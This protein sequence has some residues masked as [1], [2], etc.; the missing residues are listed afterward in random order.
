MNLRVFLP[1]TKQDFYRFIAREPEGRYEFE[2]GRIVQQMPGATRTH[3][4]LAKRIESLLEVQLDT[5][6]WEALYD[7]GVETAESVRYGDVVVSPVDE[8]ADSRATKRAA[9]VVEMLS[10]SSLARDLDV[11]PFEYMGLASLQ[12]YIV[13]SQTEAACLAWVRRSDGRFPPDPAEYQTNDVIAVPQLGIALSVAEIYRGI[14]LSSED[15]APH[16]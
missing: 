13:A 9:L 10:P 12:A 2:G 11:K 3:Q 15:T 14:V 5:A 8:A 1:V 4:R 16:G 6:K 7:W